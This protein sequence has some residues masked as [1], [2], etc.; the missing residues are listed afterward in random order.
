MLTVILREKI[1]NILQI[2]SEL[3]IIANYYNN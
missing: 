1:K 3:C 2:N